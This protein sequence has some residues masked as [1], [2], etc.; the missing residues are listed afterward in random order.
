M[1]PR[2][3]RMVA[4]SRKRAARKAQGG[5]HQLMC[6]TGSRHPLAQETHEAAPNQ[7]LCSKLL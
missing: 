2:A 1:A 4:K 5:H 7:Q 6:D 3:D